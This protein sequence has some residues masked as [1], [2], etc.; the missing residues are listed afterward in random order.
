MRT[1][2]TRF[3][4][5]AAAALGSMLPG[6]G[7][8]DPAS[9]SA[10]KP[11]APAPWL[12]AESPAGA[13]PVGS[14]K[15]TAKEGD[16][17]TVRGI[18]GGRVDPISESPAFFVIVD[19]GVYNACTAEPD[20]CATPWD[21]CCAP[22]ETLTANNATVRLVDAE[23]LPVPADLASHGIKALDAVVVVGKVGPRPDPA[24]FTIEATGIHAVGG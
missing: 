2:R 24:V 23:G 5:A 22:S 15:Q 17:V 11:Q 21:Y 1:R 19:E 12:L 20:H 9:T 14:I 6:C 16:L 3:T 10:A 18:I 8:G 4:L 13:V 7:G